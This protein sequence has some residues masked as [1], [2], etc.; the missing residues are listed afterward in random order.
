MRS[1]HYAGPYFYRDI[2][3]KHAFDQ[4]I[5]IYKYPLRWG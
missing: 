3:V 5:L 1:R 2:V 4:E